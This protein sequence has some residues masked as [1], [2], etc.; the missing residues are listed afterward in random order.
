MRGYA[1]YPCIDFVQMYDFISG[2]P[3]NFNVTNPALGINPGPYCWVN[4][5]LPVRSVL[6]SPRAAWIVWRAGQPCVDL[7][8]S[9]YIPA[10]A[11]NSSPAGG[12]VAPCQCIACL[13]TLMLSTHMPGRGCGPWMLVAPWTCQKRLAAARRW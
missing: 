2:C 1:R 9:A 11:C 7:N 5:T 10:C 6:S 12:L 3:A 13:C 8:L 4:G